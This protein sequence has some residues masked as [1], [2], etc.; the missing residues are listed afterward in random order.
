[1]GDLPRTIDANV[2]SLL[3]HVADGPFDFPTRE[4]VRS[5]GNLMEYI[6]RLEGR[7]GQKKAA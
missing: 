6:A 7:R 5:K 3:K 2:L 4:R 1:M